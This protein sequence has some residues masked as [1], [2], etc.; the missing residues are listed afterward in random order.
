MRVES[1]YFPQGSLEQPL[2][3]LTVFY[4]ENIGTAKRSIVKAWVKGFVVIGPKRQFFCCV[5]ASQITPVIMALS[6]LSRL[7]VDKLLCYS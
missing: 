2:E 4:V 5:A 3:N 6:C 1:G 7:P